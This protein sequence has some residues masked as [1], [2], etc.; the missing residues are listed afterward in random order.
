MDLLKVLTA[1]KKVDAAHDLIAD[2]CPTG[3]ASGCWAPLHPLP[4]ALLDTGSDA[5]QMQTVLHYCSNAVLRKR[6]SLL[7]FHGE[8]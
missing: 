4:A 2:S 7:V 3:S 5:P 6:L 1:K 8:G